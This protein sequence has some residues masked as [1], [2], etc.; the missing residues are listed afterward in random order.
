MEV[1]VNARQILELELEA[2]SGL[3][4]ATKSIIYINIYLQINTQKN[5]L[6]GGGSQTGRGGGGQKYN[7]G[8]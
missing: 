1:L 8:G 4:V 5:S 2:E 7:G 6:T 3:G